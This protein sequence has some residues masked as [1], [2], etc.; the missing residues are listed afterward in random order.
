[1]KAFLERWGMGESISR[2]LTAF[3]KALLYMRE[4]Y[5]PASSMTTYDFCPEQHIINKNIF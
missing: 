5:L 3:M 4:Y 1:M 2:H